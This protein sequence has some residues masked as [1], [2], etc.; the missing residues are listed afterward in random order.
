M[1]PAVLPKAILVGPLA[2]FL[3]PSVAHVVVD[4]LPV[5]VIVILPVDVLTLIPVPAIMLET[6][7]PVPVGPVAPA[8]PVGPTV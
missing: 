4:V 8:G 3:S 6:P 2:L 7:V 5:D 1:N